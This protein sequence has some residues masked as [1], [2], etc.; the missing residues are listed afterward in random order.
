MRK[1]YVGLGA[2]AIGVGGFCLLGNRIWAGEDRVLAYAW[3]CDLE[4]I[5]N[6]LSNP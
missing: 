3:C 1:Q 2:W 5:G 6:I 4:W